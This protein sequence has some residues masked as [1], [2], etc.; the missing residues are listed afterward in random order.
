EEWCLIAERN[1]ASDD[2]EGEASVRIPRS[3]LLVRAGRSDEAETTARDAV[4]LAGRT[5][6]L[7]LHGAAML[8]LADVLE[9]QGRADEAAAQIALAIAAYERKGNAAAIN[10]LE[11]RS[12]AAAA[13][14][15]T[16]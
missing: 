14:G 4:G 1:A 7:N 13:S 9:H 11:H 15:T 12:T 10:R 3:R 5:D 2:L 16:A 6:E 8:A